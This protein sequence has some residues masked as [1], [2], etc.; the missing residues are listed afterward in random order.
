M[1][2]QLDLG[3]PADEAFELGGNG[4]GVVDLGEMHA[5]APEMIEMS[6]SIV[7]VLLSAG[8]H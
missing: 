8:N 2:V 5:F 7:S 1:H 3:H 4:V 6:G